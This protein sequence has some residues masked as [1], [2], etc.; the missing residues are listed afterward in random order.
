MLPRAGL[1]GQE[2]A[3]NRREVTIAFEGFAFR[4]ARVEVTHED[5]VTLTVTA[6]ALT[7]SFTIDD[8]RIAR[9]V[10]AGRST[11]FEFRADQAGEFIF[12]C[13]LTSDARHGEEQGTLVVVGADGQTP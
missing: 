13:S 9:R 6:D 8:Y 4:P 10:A 2:A 12:Y 7:H 5:V 1:A 3:P 11:T